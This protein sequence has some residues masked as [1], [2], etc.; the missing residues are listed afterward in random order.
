MAKVIFG[1]HSAVRVRRTER[2]RIRK[3]YCDVLDC[4]ITRECLWRGPRC[5][6]TA[7]IE[8]PHLTAELKAISIL[9]LLGGNEVRFR[10]GFPHA[11]AFSML[12]EAKLA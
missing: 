8:R 11:K 4:K 7:W 2:E 10:R 6:G 1:N 9:V 3:F 12:G 5:R